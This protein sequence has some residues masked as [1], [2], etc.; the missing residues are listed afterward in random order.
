[1]HDRCPA[2][3]NKARPSCPISV[4]LQ[5][6]LGCCQVRTFKRSRRS[7]VLTPDKGAGQPAIILDVPIAGIHPNPNAGSSLNSALNR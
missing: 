4:P 3:A 2:P 5:R 1:M 6:L 7:L